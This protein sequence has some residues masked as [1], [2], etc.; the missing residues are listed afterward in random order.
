M[1]CAICARSEMG[2]RTSIAAAVTSNIGII[3]VAIAIATD[4]W[5]TRPSKTYDFYQGLWNK[6]KILHSEDE[7]TCTKIN[8]RNYNYTRLNYISIIG[9]LLCACAL[10]VINTILVVCD[11][12]LQKV[13]LQKITAC[14]QTLILSSTIAA[15]AVYTRTYDKTYYKLGWSYVLGWCG[16]C[17]ELAGLIF[18]IVRIETNRKDLSRTP[19]Y[20]YT[21]V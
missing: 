9:L 14:L 3:L 7:T 6:C 1:L 10:H 4:H 16:V 5:A 18:M 12:C 8:E 13:W 2:G 21:G 19:S 20:T 15:L 17:F 11:C